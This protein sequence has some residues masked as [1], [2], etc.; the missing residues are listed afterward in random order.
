MHALEAGSQV[1]GGGDPASVAV[2]VEL[3]VQ[4]QP[5]RD[6]ASIAVRIAIAMTRESKAGRNWPAAWKPAKPC[7]RAQPASTTSVSL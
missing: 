7:S 6:A 4:G 5:G 1:E 3:C 2:D